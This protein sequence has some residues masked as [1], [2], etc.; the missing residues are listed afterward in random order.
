MAG[1]EAVL[2]A[3]ML[4]FVVYL[5][6]LIWAFAEPRLWRLCLLLLLGIAG[7]LALQ[8]GLMTSLPRIAGAD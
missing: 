5:G 3:C 7:N 4:G 1:H 2:I 6:L 8:F